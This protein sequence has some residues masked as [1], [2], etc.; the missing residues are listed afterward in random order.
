[1]NTFTTLTGLTLDQV[2][3]KLDTELPAD[4]YTKVPGAVELT[5][6]DP[7]HMRH[8]LNSVFGLCGLGWGYDYAVADLD[9]AFAEKNVSAVCRRLTFW[10]KLQDGDGVRCF[11]VPAT[12]ASENRNPQYA[13][14]GALTNALGN[15]VS[16]LGFQE[17][18]YMGKRSHATVGRKPASPARAA[19]RPPVAP[20]PEST[21]T[22]TTSAEATTVAGDGGDFVIAVGTQYK[23]KAVKDLPASALVWFA[24]KMAATTP[25]AQAAK[26]AC[27]AFLS[28]HPEVRAAA[29]NG[30]SAERGLNG[31]VKAPA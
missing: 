10:F 5:D 4:A 11:E 15:A 27:I 26:E 24:E 25:A 18:V 3:A 13:M 22:P 31:G 30:H 21:I 17:S 1:M 16:N 2:T 7:A 14:K 12:G 23:G 19:P 28:A 9:L 8:V 6:I 29:G 20:A